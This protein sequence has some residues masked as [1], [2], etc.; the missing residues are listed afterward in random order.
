MRKGGP[1][2]VSL[3]L[4]FVSIVNESLRLVAPCDALMHF[5]C[6]SFAQDVPAVVPMV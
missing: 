1:L 5:A 3:L 2:V 6:F 4:I